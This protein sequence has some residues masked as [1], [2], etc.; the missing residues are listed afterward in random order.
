MHLSFIV[1]SVFLMSWDPCSHP[2]KYWLNVCIV[3]RI[4]QNVKLWHNLEFFAQ[5]IDN[6]EYRIWPSQRKNG[7]DDIKK[8]NNHLHIPL[9]WWMII[10]CRTGWRIL[11]E[12]Q[13]DTISLA[14]LGSSRHCWRICLCLYAHPVKWQQS[15]DGNELGKKDLIDLLIFICW[16]DCDMHDSWLNSNVILPVKGWL[17]YK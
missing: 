17:T 13:F 16:D 8:E 2:S 11:A 10:Y 5:S 7:T 15:I 3:L 14:G 12:A 9:E 1:T 4:N 6:F